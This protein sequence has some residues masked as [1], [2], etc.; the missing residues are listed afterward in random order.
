M[1]GHDVVFNLA[2]INGTRS[3]YEAPEKYWKAAWG[4]LNITK[5]IETH[6][7]DTFIYFSSSEVYQDPGVYPTPERVPLII[8]EISNPRFS[9]GGGK[10]FG[11]LTTQHL[12]NNVRRKIIIRPHNVYGPKMGNEHVIP[13]FVEKIVRAEGE[14]IEIQG[15]GEETRSFCF[16]DDAARAVEA[17]LN[18][19][20]EGVFNIGT[21]DEVTIAKLGEMVGAALGKKVEI[22]PGPLQKGSVKRRLPD[23]TRLSSLGFKPEWSLEAG[24]G[25]TADWYSYE[26]SK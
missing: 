6:P 20:E 22:C 13:N 25:V 3:F 1:S 18:S 14:K 10:I 4:Q 5:A 7:L 21:T 26:Y 23:V 11:E 15:S 8:P 2:Y 9:Y 12:I 24:L 16:I 19:S 17:I